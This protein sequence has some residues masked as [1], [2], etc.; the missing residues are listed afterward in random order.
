[1]CYRWFASKFLGIMMK[2]FVSLSSFVLNQLCIWQSWFLLNQ[3]CVW[4]NLIW[5][6]KSLNLAGLSEY[7]E[8]TFWTFQALLVPTTIC[9]AQLQLC[10]NLL[11]ASTSSVFCKDL[12]MI[13][14][15]WN[16]VLQNESNRKQTTYRKRADCAGGW[17]L[18]R[19]LQLD[20]AYNGFWS[21]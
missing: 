19:L 20:W 9:T 16:I 13:T 14:T 3:L 15:F 7:L 11:L 8:V 10:Q 17:S 1:M 6:I 4:W 18:R 2:R 5:P 21:M 12:T